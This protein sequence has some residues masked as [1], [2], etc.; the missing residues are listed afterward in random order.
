MG[1]AEQVKEH[2]DQE[3]E[4]LETNKDLEK[5]EVGHEQ[6]QRN[7]VHVSKMQRLSAT[8][9]LRLVIDNATRVPPTHIPNNRGPAIHH[10]QPPQPPPSAATQ[11][12]PPHYHPS[13]PPPQ[14]QTVNPRSI[15]SPI[16]ITPTPQIRFGETNEEEEERERKVYVFNE[17]SGWK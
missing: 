8:N 7:N 2:V 12:P 16:H 14:P 11:P 15:P 3:T 13:P 5:G 1:V 9:P 17:F 4:T 6:Q 10:Q